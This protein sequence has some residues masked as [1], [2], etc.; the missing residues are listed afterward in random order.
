MSDFPT[1]IQAFM[2]AVRHIGG[3][4]SVEPRKWYLPEI[5]VEHWSLPQFADLPLGVMRRACGIPAHEALVAFRIRPHRTE[6]G[7]RAVEFLSWWV[8]DKARGRHAI[9]MRSLALPPEAAG[10]AQL[11]STL[12]FLI[13]AFVNIEDENMGQL[14]QIV[15][16][17]ADDLAR[18]TRLYSGALALAGQVNT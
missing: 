14:L 8:R 1:E 17:Y 5:P 13:E 18:S 2:D 11:G 9:Q 15:A 10:Q 7:W 12:S 16:Q 6:Q 3:I 4:E